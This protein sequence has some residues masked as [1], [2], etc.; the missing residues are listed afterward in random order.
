M[1]K[2]ATGEEVSA[3]D[4]GGADVH[5]RTSGVTDHYAHN[6]HHALAIARQIVGNLNR[7]KN[8]ILDVRTPAPPVFD[9]NELYGVLPEDVRTPYDVHEVI[10]RIVDGSE[11]ERIQETLRHDLGLRFRPYLGLPGRDCRQQRYSVSESALKGAHFIELC[12]QRNIPLIFLQNIS[13]FMVGRK[14]EAGGIA[15][16][17]PSW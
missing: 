9:P 3:E 1:V 17:A 7:K 10:A 15:K 12:S 6:D 2:A 14:Y 4:L 11:F 8:H 13:G 5:S 16:D